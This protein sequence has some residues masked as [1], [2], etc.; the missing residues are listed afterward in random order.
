MM[1]KNL[2]KFFIIP[3]FSQE[4]KYEIH[5]RLVF[6]RGRE[7]AFRDLLFSSTKLK[8]GW[9]GVEERELLMIYEL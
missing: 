9:F 2:I 3:S 4:K 8:L 5:R 1:M 6:V 7:R